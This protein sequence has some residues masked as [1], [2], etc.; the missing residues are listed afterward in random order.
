MIAGKLESRVYLIGGRPQ[1]VVHS[2]CPEA[3][4]A[5]EIRCTAGSKKSPDKGAVHIFILGGR[6][7]ELAPVEV[8]PDAENVFVTRYVVI[9][10]DNS[11]RYGD[12]YGKAETVTDLSNRRAV[13]SIPGLDYFN[14]DFISRMVFRP[15]LDRLL[16]ECGF[17]SLHAAGVVSGRTGCIIAGNAGAGKSTLLHGLLE[18]GLDFLADDRI[19]VKK[20]NIHSFP[21]YIRLPRTKTGPKYPVVPK[22]SPVHRV[23]PKVILFL[24]KDE[25]DGKDLCKP[26]GKTEAAARLLQFLPPFTEENMLKKAFNVIGNICGEANIFLVKGWGTP[27]KRLRSVL[28]I[29]N[30]M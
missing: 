7:A 1:L 12:W 23:L 3:L 4:E 30:E 13:I 5:V 28:N 11:H 18:E 10:S 29:L 26:V 14:R 27:R 17:I 24:E 22:D 2:D 25:T 19:F 20:G 9:K 15:V 16:F 6:S 8:P 21:E